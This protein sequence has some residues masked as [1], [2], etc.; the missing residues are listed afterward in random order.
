MCFYTTFIHWHCGAMTKSLNKSDHNNTNRS[1]VV[2]CFC[3][4]YRFRSQQANV[5][6]SGLNIQD[7]DTVQTSNNYSSLIC[8]A[9][10]LSI[11]FFK[12]MSTDI[13][14]QYV[15]CVVSIRHLQQF[16]R[17]VVVCLPV[18]SF[19]YSPHLLDKNTLFSKPF[20]ICM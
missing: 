16:L 13:V 6:L 2:C 14:F 1:Q 5:V 10:V 12:L 19:S 3:G 11:V 9:F 20:C 4:R 17:F 15:H 8:D 18:N 7:C